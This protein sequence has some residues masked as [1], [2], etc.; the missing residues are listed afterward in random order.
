MDEIGDYMISPVLSIDR[1]SSVQEAA[2]FMEAH[3]IGSLLVREFDEYVGIVTET[4]LA[5][6]VLGKGLNPESTLVSEIMTSPVL[7]LD[8]YLPIEEANRFMHKN[9]IRHLGVTE[10]DKIVGILSVKDLV[11]YFSKDFRMQE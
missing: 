4:D 1:E 9:K 3:N 6:K 11:A 10:E 2:Q 7:S 5:R 8:R